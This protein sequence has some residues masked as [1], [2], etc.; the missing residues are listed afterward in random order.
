MHRANLYGEPAYEVR[1][2]IEAHLASPE[3]PRQCLE[4]HFAMSKRFYRSIASNP[5]SDVVWLQT[6]AQ[7]G[8][9]NWTLSENPVLPLLLL[10]DP[11]HEEWIRPL[12]KVW[13]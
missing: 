8:G 5:S 9:W 11:A 2:L 10:E 6:I 3:T 13:Y 12:L 4:Y 1:I 7:N